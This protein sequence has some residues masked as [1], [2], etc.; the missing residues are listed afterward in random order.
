MDVSR[1]LNPQVNVWSERPTESV[2]PHFWGVINGIN[3][4]LNGINDVLPQ[5]MWLY[6]FSRSLTP[7]I[8]LRVQYT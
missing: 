7:Y 4:V 6:R 1:V 2:K 5:K 8:H 3:D